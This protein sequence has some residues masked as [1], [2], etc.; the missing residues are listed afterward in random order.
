MDP[1]ALAWWCTL[2][3][4]SVMIAY[5]DAPLSDKQLD[6]V[7][8]KILGGMGSL[9]DFRLDDRKFGEE[10]R[11]ANR[12]LDQLSNDVYNVLSV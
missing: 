10:A 11:T 3:T 6:Y 5:Q 9:N 7:R 4:I 12:V 2:E 1:Y 8:H